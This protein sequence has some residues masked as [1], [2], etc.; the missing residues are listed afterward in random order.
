M[1]GQLVDANE[2]LGRRSFVVDSL[3][4]NV[5]RKI[6]LRHFIDS[7]LDTD[8][9]VDCLGKGEASNTNRKLLT[10]LS[11]EECSARNPGQVFDGWFAILARDLNWPG[12]SSE[13]RHL[14]ITG[15]KPNPH[16]AEISR[17][18]FRTKAQS[19]AF[20]AMIADRFSRKG[21]FVEPLN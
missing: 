11:I 15:S 14:P 10:K 16:H 18:G 9:S 12:R 1:P 4:V 7:R 21:R 2:L 19:Y 17:E 20:A 6:D 3:P 8:L 13:V 5:R